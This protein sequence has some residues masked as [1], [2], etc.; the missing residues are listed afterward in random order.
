MRFT[1][2]VEI[3]GR[4]VMAFKVVLEYVLYASEIRSKS[5]QLSR[6]RGGN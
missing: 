4:M 6:L 2:E 3:K 5:S 1:E